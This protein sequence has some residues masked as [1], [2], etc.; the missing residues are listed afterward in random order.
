MTHLRLGYWA[1]TGWSWSTHRSLLYL[2]TRTIHSANTT[3]LWG[4]GASFAQPICIE[5]SSSVSITFPPTIVSD[6]ILSFECSQLQ[7]VC[8]RFLDLFLSL[9]RQCL[10][11]ASVKATAFWEQGS[12]QRSH[13]C[14]YWRRGYFRFH[15]AP[16]HQSVSRSKRR[17][18]AR[19]APTYITY[20]RSRGTSSR[21][22]NSRGRK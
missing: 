18:Q 12:V 4:G 14:C 17:R 21:I 2:T 6:F 8:Y 19:E 7:S 1:V 16:L 5:L 13:R 20:V 10:F 9:W 15:P 22:I 3:T 11:Y